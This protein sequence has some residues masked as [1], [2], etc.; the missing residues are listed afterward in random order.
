MSSL[1]RDRSILQ[2]EVADWKWAKRESDGV[3]RRI[4]ALVP[5]DVEHEDIFAAVK[6]TV[7]ERD[8]L[9]ARV[10][11]AERVRVNYKALV[12]N[13]AADSAYYKALAERRKNG[14]KAAS[15]T[16]HN[17]RHTEPYRRTE[18]TWED[19][20][21]EKCVADRAAIEEELKRKGSARDEY[22]PPKQVR[23]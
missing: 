8:A 11:E 17:F 20:T 21:E 3:I 6:R 19:C 1:Q 23:G 18:L 4:V 10:E 15:K 13:W 16:W 22:Q 12:D 9:Q 5:R 14:W 2:R 7:Q